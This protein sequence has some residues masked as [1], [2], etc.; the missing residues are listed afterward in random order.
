VSN[1][2]PTNI[3]ASI[4]AKLT[5]KAREFKI[6]P[7]ILRTRYALER[8]LYRLSLS[9]YK[10]RLTPKGAMLF[11]L[12]SDEKF[13]PTKDADFLLT[14]ESDVD[15]VEKMI[16]E[17]C[18]IPVQEDDAMRY[19]PESVRAEIIREDQA[20]GGVRATLA[21]HLG[22]ITVPIQLDI[23]VG[24]V[25]TP[26]SEQVP[27]SV[28]MKDFPAPQLFVYSRESMVAEKL[29]AMVKLDLANS[30]MKDFYDV[31]VIS[32]Q[33]G[34]DSDI[35]PKAILATF[36]RRGTSFPKGDIPALTSYFYNDEKKNIQWRAFLKKGKVAYGHL[37]L[38]QVCEEISE[39]LREVFKRIIQGKICIFP[40]PISDSQ[41]TLGDR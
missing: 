23:G 17:I 14:G 8:F 25:V 18:V 10:R 22:K 30:R 38:K 19:D 33:L 7:N 20:Y 11:V 41:T 3:A 35:M 32:T 2:S 39:S 27:F 12:W 34:F 4:H 26:K 1:P 9:Q 5:N 28:L 6:D 36:K 24:D 29:E 13:R 31:W 37:T 40:F 16:K 21:A 15:A